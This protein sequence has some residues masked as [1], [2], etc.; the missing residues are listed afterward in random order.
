MISEL[1][2]PLRGGFMKKTPAVEAN[3]KTSGNP[4]SD[5]RFFTSVGPEDK[6]CLGGQSVLLW[7]FLCDARLQQEH[8]KSS[9]S[10]PPAFLQPQRVSASQPTLDVFP[11]SVEHNK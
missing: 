6:D 10:V 4:P 9:S 8:P 3:H 1:H 7:D 11:A 5:G 2:L